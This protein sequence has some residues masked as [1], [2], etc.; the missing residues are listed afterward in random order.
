MEGRVGPRRRPAAGSVSTATTSRAPRARAESARTPLPHPTSTTRD[1]RAGSAATSDARAS[2]AEACDPLPNARPGS[3]TTST[4]GAPAG[5][6][7]EGWVHR[8]VRRTRR[9][10]ARPVEPLTGPRRAAPPGPY[11]AFATAQL[12]SSPLDPTGEP[13]AGPEAGAPARGHPPSGGRRTVT[14]ADRHGLGRRGAT[15]VEGGVEVDLH[16][17]AGATAR[18]PHRRGRPASLAAG[19]HAATSMTPPR[20]RT[21]ERAASSTAAAPASPRASAASSA[22]DASRCRDVDGP[23]RGRTARRSGRRASNHR[24]TAAASHDPTSG[25]ARP[26]PPGHAG[27]V[28]APSV[29][30][31]GGR[32]MP[33]AR[34]VATHWPRERPRRRRGRVGP[35]RNTCRANPQGRP[36]PPARRHG[37]HG[38][39]PGTGLAR[40]RSRRRGDRSWP[41]THRR[42]PNSWTG[43]TAPAGETGRS[44]PL[45]G[46]GA[47]ARR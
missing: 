10:L 45:R 8:A 30:T 7:P 23:H 35:R 15:G 25:T 22:L 37:R 17:S 24:S 47:R 29:E 5:R 31:V 32:P 9:A 28:T 33:T 38:P 21:L 34:A 14:G 3:I 26:Q 42:R 27:A 36:W 39:A 40:P 18:R 46:G 16:P 13:L 12:A 44:T 2:R 11:G 6:R 4:P 1:R 19:H 41:A 43:A 20:R